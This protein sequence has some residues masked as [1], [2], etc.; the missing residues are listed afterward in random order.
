M[1]NNKDYI[2]PSWYIQTKKSIYYILG[3][4]EVLLG[5]RLV[6]KMLG[7]NAGNGLVNALYTMTKGLTAPF[8]G[9]FSIFAKR[10]AAVS[11]VFEPA[12]ILAMIIYAII[13][14]GIINLIKLKVLE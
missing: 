7:A 3:V 11:V 14:V 4:I 9:I 6:F 5:F 1:D 13:A 12:T 10:S 8:S 2:F